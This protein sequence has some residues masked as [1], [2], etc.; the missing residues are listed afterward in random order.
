PAPASTRT[1][2]FAWT[3]RLAVSGE[4]ATRVSPARL[5]RGTNAVVIR[6]RKAGEDSGEPP[7]GP[8]RSP[9]LGTDLIS[10]PPITD[11]LYAMRKWIR[12]LSFAC[13]SL[14]VALALGEGAV[15]LLQW[16]KHGTTSRS[17][18]DF[19]TDPATKLRIPRPGSRVGAIA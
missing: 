2:T 9:R 3:R 14:V 10:R 12:R 19:A 6:R 8:P 7:R 18:Y 4:A 1:S 13:G 15:R 17:V 11:L 5:S 16:M